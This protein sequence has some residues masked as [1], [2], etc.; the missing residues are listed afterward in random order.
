MVKLALLLALFG[1]LVVL[2]FVSERRV[3]S[4]GHLGPH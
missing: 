2:T 3:L 1:A 4:N